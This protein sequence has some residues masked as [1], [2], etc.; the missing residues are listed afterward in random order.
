MRNLLNFIAFQCCWFANV[1]SAANGVPWLG[2][3]VTALWLVGHLVSLRGAE[4]PGGIAAEIRVL[5]AAIVIGWTADSALTLAGLISFAENAQLGGPS[6][7]WMIAL[8]TCFAATLRHSLGWL[9]AR[10]LLAI[11]LGAVGGPLAYLGG[12]S[13]GAIS[14]T[15][16]LSIAAISAQ[17]AIA[18]PILL[19]IAHYTTRAARRSARHVQRDA[20]VESGL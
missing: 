10:W 8:W 19:A 9:R 14:L 2:P 4:A 18:T 13:L 1:I 5:L 7:L 20:T 16:D 15:G 11:V 3:L 17:Y 6:P 12:E